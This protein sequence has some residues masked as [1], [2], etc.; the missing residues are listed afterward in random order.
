MRQT[1]RAE[2]KGHWREMVSLCGMNPRHLHLSRAFWEDKGPLASTPAM[3]TQSSE[4]TD[5][6]KIT[7]LTDRMLY[8][9]LEEIQS[10]LG[11][12]FFQIS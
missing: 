9:I 8:S 7:M 4:T 1:E 2:T 3:L 10:S 5:V 6:Q 11:H 12:T